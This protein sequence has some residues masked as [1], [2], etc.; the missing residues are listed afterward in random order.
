MRLPWLTALVSTSLLGS[1]SC[2]GN[3]SS[4]VSD[5]PGATDGTGGA[6][7]ALG[8]APAS[9]AGASGAS[10]SPGTSGGGLSSGG[11]SSGGAS[12]GTG[13]AGAPSAG[14]NAGTSS[15]GAG[16]GGATI[17][18]ASGAGGL[19]GAGG[20]AGSSAVFPPNCTCLGLGPPACSQTGH[21]SYTLAKAA[22]PNADQLSAY[23]AISCAMDG[24]I[25]YYN[26][27]TSIT[28]Q[29]NVSYD[30]G[31]PTADGNFNGS[32][33]FGGRAYMECVTGMHE[34][35]HTVGVGTAPKWSM[36][37]VGGVFTGTNAILQ[38]RAI[39]GNAAD[40]LHSDTQHFGHMGS[41]TR[42]KP[43]RPPT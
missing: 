18:G 32:V 15:A 27:N 28:K 39:T 17:G 11:L 43:G 6:N 26:C 20:S 40:V 33:R 5:T 35:A 25:A 7:S 1:L 3:S 22:A 34:I 8:G 12:G 38:L 30:P 23:D 14:G 36:F 9:N 10:G 37:S 4:G 13:S 42:A 24:A 31:V 2:S 21:V 16:S 41:T 19:T 29:L